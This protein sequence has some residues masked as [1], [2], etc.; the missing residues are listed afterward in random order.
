MKKEEKRKHRGMAPQD[1]LFF[2]PERVDLLRE[3]V[4]DLSYLRH[5]GYP[6]KASVAL[7]GNH[8]QLTARERLALA[9]AASNA[10]KRLPPVTLHAL[11]GA[12]LCIDGFN[13][14]ILLESA[15]GGGVLIRGRDG[16][17][18]DIA[19][20]HGSYRIRAETAEAITL[21]A[22]ELKRLK[23]NKAIWYFDRPVSNSGR[24]AKMV[25]EVASKYESS[26]PMEAVTADR[27]DTLLK[28]CRGVVVTADSA[29]LEAGVRWFDLGGW[30][31]R[32][33]QLH[34]NI[35]DLAPKQGE[36]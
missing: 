13:L 10:E 14:L 17:I 27:V 8:Y 5:R 3:A 23:V 21:V 16:L 4:S 1:R 34:A 36:K 29:I 33:R 18:R 24:I 22:Q 9:H 32:H 6:Q 31:L 19:N 26:I 28:K 12:T 15:L 20:I 35:V 25:Q 7:I 11:E 30:I 2:D